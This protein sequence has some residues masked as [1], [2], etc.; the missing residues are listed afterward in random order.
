MPLLDLFF[1]FAELLLHFVDHAVDRRHEVFGLIVRDKIMLVLGRHL[2]INL[3][4]G[5]IGEIHNDVDG[6]QSTNTFGFGK[7][8]A[9]ASM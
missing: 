5:F 7:P 4:S 2:Q 8:S 3:W 9:S 1:I 6:S